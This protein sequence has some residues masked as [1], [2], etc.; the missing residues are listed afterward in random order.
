MSK[1]FKLLAELGQVDI[2]HDVYWDYDGSTSEREQRF[3]SV[4]AAYYLGQ[5]ARWLGILWANRKSGRI[6]TRMPWYPTTLL[7]MANK[8]LL[9]QTAEL[10]GKLSRLFQQ[11][12]D[13][14][15][16]HD[17]AAF[18][19][20]GVDLHGDFHWIDLDSLEPLSDAVRDCPQYLCYLRMDL[21]RYWHVFSLYEASFRSIRSVLAINATACDS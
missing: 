4:L 12:A 13:V 8:G 7:A 3:D 9:D 6:C 19:N 2:E 15:L 21:K 20:I 18:R 5:R 14:G 10:A 1:S 11:T 17:D 16:A